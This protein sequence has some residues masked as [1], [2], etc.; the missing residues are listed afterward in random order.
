MPKSLIEAFSFLLGDKR[1]FSVPRTGAVSSHL[2]DGYF[3]PS[4]VSL[5]YYLPTRFHY[6]FEMME[7]ID[8]WHSPRLNAYSMSS[9]V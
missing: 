7:A 5:R 1:H 9:S 4:P 6:E 2:S 8:K 3:Q